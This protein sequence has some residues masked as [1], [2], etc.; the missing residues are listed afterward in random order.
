MENKTIT[1]NKH[2]IWDNNNPIIL[3]RTKT[4]AGERKIV[5]LDR[6]F[7]KLPKFK[8]LLFCNEDGSPLT[9]GQLRKRW[10]KYQKKYEDYQASSRNDLLL[11]EY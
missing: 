5:I 4:K 11:M 7:E 8:G 6:L 2:I 1:I 9:K 10:E 3:P